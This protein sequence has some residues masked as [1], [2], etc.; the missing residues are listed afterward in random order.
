MKKAEIKRIA[1]E[2][3][4]QEIVFKITQHRGQKD[5]S[6]RTFEQALKD[7][8]DEVKKTEAELEEA[9]KQLRKF[10]NPDAGGGVYRSHAAP[11]A[12]HAWLAAVALVGAAF[13][14]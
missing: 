2:K 8:E 14:A 10:R 12:K 5:T 11:A 4:G 1:A 3:T 7:E 9:A 6:K 13:A